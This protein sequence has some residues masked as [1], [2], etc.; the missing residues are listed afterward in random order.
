MSNNVNHPSH[1]K[2]A[3]DRD[4]LIHMVEMYGAVEVISFCKLNA[5]KYISRAGRKD[6]KRT[7][8]DIEKAMEYLERIKHLLHLPPSSE[9]PKEKDGHNEAINSFL[10]KLPER[11]H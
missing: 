5:L 8:E 3:D 6:P 11:Y 1:Y 10:D 2:M 9:L 7:K 4:L